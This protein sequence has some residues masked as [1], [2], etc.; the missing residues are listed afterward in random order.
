MRVNWRLPTTESAFPSYRAETPGCGKCVRHTRLGSDFSRDFL[1]H[2]SY[3]V[4]VNNVSRPLS[5]AT[6]Q[7]ATGQASFRAEPH[8]V[9]WQSTMKNSLA[10]VFLIGSSGAGK[11]TFGRR[12]A[13]VLAVQFTDLDVLYR[14]AGKN[15]DGLRALTKGVVSQS[16]WVLDG[17]RALIRDLVASRATT[18]IYLNYRYHTMVRRRVQRTS[19]WIRDPQ[20]RSLGRLFDHLLWAANLDYHRRRSGFQEYLRGGAYPNSSILE[21]QKPRH[22]E[23]FLQSLTDPSY[24]PTDEWERNAQAHHEE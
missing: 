12:L 8:D 23:A 5:I 1:L 9:R 10:R 22:A 3:R 11:T 17:R 21:F 14:Q 2:F 16:Q 24:Q 4:V 13:D 18:V 15:I 6:S 20:N 7:W 19:E